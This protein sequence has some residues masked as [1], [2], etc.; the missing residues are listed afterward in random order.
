[1]VIGQIAM[2]LI[3][4]GIC[5]ACLKGFMSDCIT[6]G[7]P[8]RPYLFALA[9]VGAYISWLYGDF[10]KFSIWGFE[11]SMRES[12]VLIALIAAAC[13]KTFSFRQNKARLS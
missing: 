13:W 7:R 6:H 10:F 2:Y 8:I 9:G 11:G 12:S 5:T 1:M 3:G 4:L